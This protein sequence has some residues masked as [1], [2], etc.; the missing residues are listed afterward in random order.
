MTQPPGLEAVLGS[1]DGLGIIAS[2]V[3]SAAERERASG[4]MAFGGTA[5]GAR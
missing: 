4:P 1:D 3:A 5:V 2:F